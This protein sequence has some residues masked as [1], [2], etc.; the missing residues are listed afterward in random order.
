MFLQQLKLALCCNPNKIKLYTTFKIN[1]IVIG[2][3]ITQITVVGDMY[4][5]EIYSQALF[6]Y[7]YH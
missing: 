6:N 3:V 4:Y 1:S 7:I 5:S 2:D